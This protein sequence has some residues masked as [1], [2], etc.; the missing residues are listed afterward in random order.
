VRGNRGSRGEVRT[1]KGRE[2]KALTI[3]LCALPNSFAFAMAI[4]REGRGVRKERGEGPSLFFSL[5]PF[6]EILAK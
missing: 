4:R 1:D 5:S 6:R 3:P 2:N